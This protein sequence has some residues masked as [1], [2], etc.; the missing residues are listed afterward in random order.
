[1]LGIRNAISKIYRISALTVIKI[2]KNQ[3]EI[4]SWE[5]LSLVYKATG[6]ADLTI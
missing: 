3:N 2:D 5:K 1:M 4:N 6:D